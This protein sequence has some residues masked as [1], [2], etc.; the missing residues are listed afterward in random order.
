MDYS[1]AGSVY[2][3]LLYLFAG[4]GLYS[5]IRVDNYLYCFPVEVGI[6]ALAYGRL[7]WRGNAD[8]CTYFPE[9][10]VDEEAS[11][12]RNRLAGRAFMGIDSFVYHIRM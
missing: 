6:Y 5:A 3:L 9:L 7:A 8:S 4:T 12:L 11:S 2:I 1:Q 10:S